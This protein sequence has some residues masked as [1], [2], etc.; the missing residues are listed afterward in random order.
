ML[1]FIKLME[2]KSMNVIK[3]V[4]FNENRIMKAGYIHLKVGTEIIK[5]EK[6]EK[7]RNLEIIAI[8]FYNFKL[9]K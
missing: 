1:P 7:I 2:I 6:E 8:D 3:A 9:K 4:E 5:M